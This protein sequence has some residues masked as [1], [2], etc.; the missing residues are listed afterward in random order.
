MSSPSQIA[1][2]RARPLSGLPGSTTP[3]AGQGKSYKAYGQDYQFAERL[4]NPPPEFVIGSIDPT[5]PAVAQTDGGQESAGSP[6]GPA[7]SFKES[8]TQESIWTPPPETPWYKRI[9]RIWWI[10]IAITVVGSTAVIFAILAAM[11]TFAGHT[12]VVP[13]QH[14]ERSVLTQSSR[15]SD[16][17]GQSDNASTP[18]TSCTGASCSTSTAAHPIPTGIA[19]ECTD[20]KTFTQHVDWAGVVGSQYNTSFDHPQMTSPEACCGICWSSPGCAS[21]LYHEGSVTACVW[22][23]IT[24]VPDGGSKADDDCPLGHAPS[25]A[26]KIVP[27]SNGIAGIG[28]CSGEAT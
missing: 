4:S 28:R 5:P 13:L 7:G 20:S 10:G 9:P 22:L 16:G 27:E 21:W 26:F 18:T 2:P 3:G 23:N 11:G 12:L 19:K 8:H 17:P 15:T 14:T 1:E 6:K 25:T 24:S